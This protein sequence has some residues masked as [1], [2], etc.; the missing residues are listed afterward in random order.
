MVHGK[1]KKIKMVIMGNK[2]RSKGR[3]VYLERTFSMLDGFPGCGQIEK[4]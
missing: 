4:D 3:M 1:K 2:R